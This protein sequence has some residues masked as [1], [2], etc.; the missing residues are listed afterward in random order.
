MS[1]LLDRLFGGSDDGNDDGL[2][3]LQR[4]LEDRQ[5]NLSLTAVYGRPTVSMQG[6]QT[7]VFPC[8]LYHDGE[9]YGAH[10]KE[11]TIPDGGLDDEDAP[12][13]QFLERHGITTI[14]DIGAIEGA[15]ERATLNDKGDIEVGQ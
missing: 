5:T 7:A 1:G 4:L 9:E 8:T 3:A 2:A 10:V 15:E 11:F 12:L 14:Q 13:T 6:E